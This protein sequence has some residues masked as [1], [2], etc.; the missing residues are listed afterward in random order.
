MIFFGLNLNKIKYKKKLTEICYVLNIFMFLV[1]KYQLHSNQ[2]RIKKNVIFY[3]T[4]SKIRS[5]V[6]PIFNGNVLKQIYDCTGI[7]I[8]DNFILTE[9][10]KNAKYPFEDYCENHRFITVL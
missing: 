6:E 9:R 8:I 7:R 5:C 4:L 3:K 1:A 2:R 10:T